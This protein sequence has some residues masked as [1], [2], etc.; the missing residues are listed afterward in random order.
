[1][2]EETEVP[3][4]KMKK[5]TG[6]SQATQGTWTNVAHNLNQSKILSVDIIMSIP[7][8]VN[9]PPNYTFQAGYE[10]QYQISSTNYCSHQYYNK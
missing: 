9:L 7:A 2:G 3:K 4:I 1:M 8:F 6:I 5:L 10:Y